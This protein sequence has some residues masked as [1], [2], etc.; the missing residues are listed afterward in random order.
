MGVLLFS[1]F[2]CPVLAPDSKTNKKSSANANG[3]AQQSQCM[4]ESKVK[5]SLSQSPEAARRAAAILSIVFYS[6]SPEGVTSLAQQM[7]YRLDIANFPHPFP[8]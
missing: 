1:P 7:P 4:F 8:I 5:L 3:N 2:V 6:Y